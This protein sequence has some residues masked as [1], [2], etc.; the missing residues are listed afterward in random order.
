ML[1]SPITPQDLVKL[2]LP[3]M[4]ELE[5]G[6][7]FEPV[8]PLTAINMGILWQVKVTFNLSPLDVQESSTD[9]RIGEGRRKSFCTSAGG[10][11][12]WLHRLPF[13]N[14]HLQKEVLKL[15]SFFYPFQKVTTFS[16]SYI[17]VVQL[18][19]HVQ[20]F[21]NPINYRA[22]GSSV[23]GISQARILDWVAIYFSRG[24]FQPRDQTSIS[25]IGRW[26]LY[27]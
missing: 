3:R 13:I 14:S 4:Q 21:C 2:Q 23:Q 24:S 11:D 19:S 6:H 16:E 12:P 25:C 22:K 7:C 15:I 8:L 9:Y 5:P 27:H 10:R 17:V 1:E 18:L 26:I 20:L